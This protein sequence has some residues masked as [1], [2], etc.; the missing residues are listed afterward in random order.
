MSRRKRSSQRDP[1]AKGDKPIADAPQKP[2]S[3]AEDAQVSVEGWKDRR[4][5]MRRQFPGPHGVD[6]PLRVALERAAYAEVVAHA[7]ESLDAEICGVLVGTDCV[8]DDGPFVHAQAAIRGAKAKEGSAHVTFTQNT[9]NNI[10]ETIE[11]EYPKLQIVGWYH[12]HPGFGVAFSEMD[13]FIQKNFFPGATQI[14]MVTDPLGGEVAIC[15]NQDDGIRYVPRFWVDAREQ[16]CYRP[17]DDDAMAASGGGGGASAETVAALETRVTQLI[18]AV[19]D[20]RRTF[21]RWVTTLGM[22]IGFAIIFFI[23]KLFVQM[24]FGDIPEPPKR[25]RFLQVPV[26]IDGHACL[27]GVDVVQW[28]IPPELY[29]FPKEEEASDEKQEKPD[30]KAAANDANEQ[31]T[32][33]K[34]PK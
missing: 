20:A 10:H 3:E 17:E 7:K 1:G 18:Q 23:A 12:S 28:K 24:V 8:D 14:A 13:I 30:D 15:I 34:E 29:A 22:L 31:R 26:E 2:L 33:S 9:W 6:V 5:P 25:I 21:Y 27:L 16:K 11:K 19:D 32:K 4:K